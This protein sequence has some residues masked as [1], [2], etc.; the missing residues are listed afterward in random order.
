MAA[1]F[2]ARFARSARKCSVAFVLVL[3][4]YFGIGFVPHS[5]SLK[6]TMARE[7]RIHPNKYSR[8]TFK[9]DKNWLLCNFSLVHGFQVRTIFGDLWFVIGDEGPPL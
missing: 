7:M 3:N 9:D 6:E 1:N 8:R 5:F 4:M 2:S